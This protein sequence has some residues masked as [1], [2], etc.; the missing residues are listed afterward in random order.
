MLFHK[1]GIRSP[2]GISPGTTGSGAKTG[3]FGSWSKT[4]LMLGLAAVITP[5]GLIYGQAAPQVGQL[6]ASGL[7]VPY[8]GAWINGSLGGHF[9]QPDN[10]LGVCR[11][12][13]GAV[14]S[15]PAT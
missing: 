11:I 14:S 7:T 13:N 3:L 2:E 9:W 15:A 10:A 5:Q 6:V 1:E 8:G 12:D 4:I